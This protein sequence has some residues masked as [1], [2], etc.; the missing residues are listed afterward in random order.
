MVAAADNVGDGH[1]ECNRD[2]ADLASSGWVLPAHGAH[3]RHHSWLGPE[4]PCCV[5][6]LHARHPT[7]SRTHAAMRDCSLV[8]HGQFDLITLDSFSRDSLA[9]LRHKVGVVKIDVEGFEDKA[10]PLRAARLAGAR[11]RCARTA[12]RRHERCCAARRAG[13]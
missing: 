11:G 7:R 5:G 3:R 2:A 8:V 1:V 4:N 10:R 12:M 6:C 9:A 13:F